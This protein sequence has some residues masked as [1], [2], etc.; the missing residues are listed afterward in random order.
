MADEKESL[1]Q[2]M[3]RVLAT[4]VDG[5]RRGPIGKPLK[6]GL[7]DNAYRQAAVLEDTIKL[8]GNCDE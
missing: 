3:R 4:I 2:L 7:M 1:E 8:M 6:R 5:Q